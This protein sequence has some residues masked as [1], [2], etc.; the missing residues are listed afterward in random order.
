[1]KFIVAENAQKF[2]YSATVKSG[3]VCANDKLELEFV[4]PIVENGIRRG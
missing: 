3:T 1:V 4:E 2:S